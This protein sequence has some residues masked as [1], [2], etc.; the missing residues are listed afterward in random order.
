MEDNAKGRSKCRQSRHLLVPEN[1]RP[2]PTIEHVV[3]VYDD[4][5]DV[6]TEV[7]FANRQQQQAR[8]A[9]LLAKVSCKNG[10]TF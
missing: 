7:A 10:P 9:I 2:A 5:A 3:Q 6:Q 4:R 1:F 8:R